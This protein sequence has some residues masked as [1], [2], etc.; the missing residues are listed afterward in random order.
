MCPGLHVPRPGHGSTKVRLSELVQ[1]RRL[2]TARGKRNE[3][4]GCRTGLGKGRGW[5]GP[6]A[7]WSGKGVET[8]SGSWA[9][10]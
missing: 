9:G 5:V 4:G 10:S 7:D 6:W 8:E 2:G 3:A 1:H